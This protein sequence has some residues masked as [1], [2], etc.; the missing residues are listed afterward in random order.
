M[1]LSLWVLL[2]G[3]MCALAQPSVDAV[4]KERAARFFENS[5]LRFEP[6]PDG[7]AGRFVARGARFSYEFAMNEAVLH[8]AKRDLRLQFADAS[9]EAKVA[10]EETLRSRTGLYFGSDPGRWKRDVPNYGRLRV[11][12][13]YRGVDLVYY[14]NAGELEYDLKVA[15]GTDPREIRMRLEGERAHVDRAG[16]LIAGIIQKHPVAYQTS[17]DGTKVAV[18]SRYRKNADGSYGFALGPYDK[19]RELVIDPVLTLSGYL[20][21]SLQDV[22]SAV[23]L[24]AKGFIYVAGTT[25]S[26]DFQLNGN[27]YQT[28][29]G[30][31]SDIFV[32]KIDPNFQDVIYASYLGGSQAE[33]LNGMVVGPA[34]DMYVLGTTFSSNLPTINPAQ[35]SLANSSGGSSAFVA[36]FDSNQ[37]LNYC[38]YFGGKGS[39]VGG[40]I[41]LD[42]KSNMWITGGTT[43]SNLPL[44]NAIQNGYYAS[45]DIFVASINPR[46]TGSSSVVYATYFGGASWDIGRGIA[47]APDGTIWVA[48]ATYSTDIEVQGAAY[49]ATYHGGGDAWVAHFDPSLGANG[50]LY[51]SYLGGS[52]EEQ[53]TNVVVDS[54]GRATVAGYTI[55]SDFPI[56]SGALQT[57]YGG[58]TD[59]FLSVF[60]TT[61]PAT[62]GSGTLAY[63][64]YFGGTGPDTPYDLK[65]DANGLLYLTGLT[66]SAGLPSTS[67]ALQSA[68]DGTIDA[69][70]LKANLAHSG[71]AAVDY[72]SYLGSDGIQGG[73]GVAFDSNANIYLAGGTSG[74]IFSAFGGA[75]KN[76]L[77]G[78]MD[79]YIVGFS[80]CPYTLSS[81]GYQFPESGGSF[82]VTITSSEFCAWTASSSASWVTVSPSSASGTGTVDITA[83]PNTTG[84]SRQGSLTIAGQN[85]AVG[86]YQ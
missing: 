71:S 12:N 61:N 40:A 84:A 13:L 79:G 37:S 72:F 15:P 83:A 86:Q 58:N 1:K 9:P 65:Q 48:G 26:T 30:G 44:I 31:S 4:S 11:E 73:Y 57:K 47:V 17:A 60:D 28:S 38:S 24:D 75:G 16:N 21:G 68:Y 29:N 10:G 39:D 76:T 41:A 34:G 56:T 78:N 7:S 77:A 52:S 2:A 25:Y 74:P 81:G 5:R 46:T 49:Q 64:T 35:S 62:P 18:A 67:N 51:A 23:G 3:S 85:F 33:T 55:S 20:W 6:S 80:G 69:F 43:S 66:L 42:G 70:I 36:W 54:K 8:G 45:Q 50:L 63:S 14:G 22:A 32:A 82:T 59:V 27:S 53:A 19:S